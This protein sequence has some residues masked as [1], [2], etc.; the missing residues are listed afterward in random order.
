MSLRRASTNLPSAARG[1]GNVTR[2][3]LGDLLSVV[4]LGLDILGVLCLLYATSQKHIDMAIGL[5]G[6]EGLREWF[7]DDP[8]EKQDW[9]QSAARTRKR[10]KWVR[11]VYLAAIIVI[12]IGFALQILG[13]MAG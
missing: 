11:K 6:Y 1:A 8:E 3:I 7:E 10:L 12:V 5:A 2:V 13:I 4:G 9:E